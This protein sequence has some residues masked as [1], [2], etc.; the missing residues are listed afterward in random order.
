MLY[1]VI[2]INFCSLKL[3][4][5]YRNITEVPAVNKNENESAAIVLYLQTTLPILRYPPESQA[6]HN[7]GRASSFFLSHHR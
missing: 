3:S 5:L 4:Y 1:K 2:L 7:Q 6:F